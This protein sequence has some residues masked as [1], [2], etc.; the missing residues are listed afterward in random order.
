VNGV[1]QGGG[2]V[3]KEAIVEHVKK[4]K[5]KATQLSSL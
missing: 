5:A 4:V 3:L 1:K 2:E